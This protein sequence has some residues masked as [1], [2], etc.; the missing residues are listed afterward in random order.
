MKN[1]GTVVLLALL[2]AAGCTPAG[3]KDAAP[4]AEAPALYPDYTDIVIPCN[5]APLNFNVLNPGDACVAVLSGA[6]ASV[7]LRGP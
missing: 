4:A 3:W 2:L 7:V 5:I 6:D 1:C